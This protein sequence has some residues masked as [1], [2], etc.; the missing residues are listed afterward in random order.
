LDLDNLSCLECGG[1][2]LGIGLKWSVGSDVGARRDGCAVSNALENFLA[3]VDLGN[4]LSQKSITA[5]TKL[6]DAG[7]LFDPSCS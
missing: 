3:F 6:D 2:F 4:F 7:V 1:S 5:L